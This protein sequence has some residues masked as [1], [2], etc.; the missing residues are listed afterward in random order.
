MLGAVSL[1]CDCSLGVYEQPRCS[2]NMVARGHGKFGPIIVADTRKF[3]RL[4]KKVEGHAYKD[5]R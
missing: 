2:A 1:M 3:F 5:L 4:K